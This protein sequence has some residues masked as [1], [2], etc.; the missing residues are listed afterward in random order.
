VI[1]NLCASGTLPLCLYLCREN[2]TNQPFF[3]QNKPNSPIVQIHLTSFMTMNYAILTSLT[4]VKNKPNQ[5]QFKAKTNPIKANFGPISR[6]ANPIQ[7]QT[8]LS[9]N[10]AV[11]DPI[12][13]KH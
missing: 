3:M 10:V 4:K 12:S 11:G 2:F 6:V 9:S 13:K 7:T 1:Q 5:T 8:N